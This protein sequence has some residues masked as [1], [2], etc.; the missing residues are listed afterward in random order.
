MAD[1]LDPEIGRFLRE[2]AAADQRAVRSVRAD[3][4]LVRALPHTVDRRRPVALVSAAAVVL[5]AAV[6]GFAAG[7]TT[8]PA[9]SA[10]V[11]AGNGDQTADP[12]PLPQTT[13]AT[14]GFAVSGGAPAAPAFTALFT[15]TTADGVVIRAYRQDMD[16]LTADTQ[17]E[18]ACPTGAWCPPPECMP[19]M[20]LVAELST[21]AVAVQQW[22]MGYPLDAVDASAQ[23]IDAGQPEGAPISAQAVRVGADVASVR[24]EWPDGTVDEMSPVGEWAVVAHQG[25]DQPVLTITRLGDGGT[26]TIEPGDPNGLPMPEAC[27]PPAPPPGDPAAVGGGYVVNGGPTTAVA[28]N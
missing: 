19:T 3:E 9:P 16:P 8:S 15:R 5:I 7:R 4:V 17:Q 26:F 18:P 10:T 22:V 23:A 20:S 24:A 14:R 21:E 25:A 28:P 1:D 2:R 13:F 12:A 6:L 27:Q 11:A